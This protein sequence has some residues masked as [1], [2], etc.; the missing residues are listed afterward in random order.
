MN[1]NLFISLI[2]G[3]ALVVTST[4]LLAREQGP[5]EPISFEALDTNGDGQITQQ[6][7]SATR[8]ARFSDVDTDGDGLLSLE[9]LEAQGAAR[10]KTRAER[11]MERLDANADGALS[12]DELAARD[13][14]GKMFERADSNGDGAISKEEFDSARA[15]L[16]ERGRD[17]ASR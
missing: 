13:R 10:A 8:D 16:R 3:T 1:K 9:E 17:R 4:S 7:M 15:A 2:V 6:E 14:G 5:R 12:S 11:M